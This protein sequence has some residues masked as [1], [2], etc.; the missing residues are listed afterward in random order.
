MLK[1]FQ[2]LF[3]VKEFSFVL[4]FRLLMCGV[5]IFVVVMKCSSVLSVINNCISAV[6]Y[7]SDLKWYASSACLNDDKVNA[8]LLYVTDP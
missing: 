1:K 4:S 8:I 3:L 6:I 2:I 5:F 7:L